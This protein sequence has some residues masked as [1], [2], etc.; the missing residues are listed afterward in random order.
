MSTRAMPRVRVGLVG[1][2]FVARLHAEA[3]RHVRGVHVELAWVTASRPERATAF[4]AEFGAQR[5][6]DDI[7]RI[8][9]DP[10]VDLVDLCV[11][12]QLHA[13]FAVEVARAGKHV[14]VEKPLTGFFG[15]AETPR[16]DMLARALD[17]ADAVIDACGK[18]SVR[19]CYAENWVYAPPVQKARRLLA[20]SGG[21]ILRLIGEESHSGTHAPINKRWE[22]GGGG[23]LL[24]KGCHPLGAALFL[25]ADEGRRLRGRPVRP[26]SVVGEVA[27]LADTPTFQA[28]APRYLNTVDGSDVED[29]GSMLLTFDDGTVAQISASD[30]V[31]GGIRNQLAI[32]GAKAVVLC[33]INPNDTVQAYAPD[34]SIFAGEYIT[35]KIETKAGWTFPQP[36]EDW[37]TGYPQEIEDFVHSV[38]F[39]REPL[40]GG[41]LA[42]DVTAVIYGAY[43]SAAEGRRVDLGT[44]LR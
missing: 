35:E 31:L 11:P 13:P 39:G 8:L 6:A 30:A 19:L 38:A 41:E 20:A 1:A 21:P 9:D 10:D 22:T 16:R 33:H 27:Q 14:V 26:A 44:F 3:Y 17:S 37:M 28:A 34:A 23:S 18:A 25:K 15:P 12:S 36:D 42:R 5:T 43:L 29:W 32:Y 24:G 7:R 4:A 40:S 2:G